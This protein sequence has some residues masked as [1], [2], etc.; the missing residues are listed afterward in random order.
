[1]PR[2]PYTLLSCAVSVDGCLDDASADRLILSGPED[3]DEVDELRAS[4]DAILVGAGTIRADDPRL[5]VRSPARAARRA[6]RGA[7]DQPLRVTLTGTGDLGPG[8]RFFLG[9][10]TPLVYCA[11]SAVAALAGRLGDAAVVV[12]AGDP[13]SLRNVLFDLS[14]RTVDSV[15]I[16]GGS[17]VLRDALEGDLA[18]ELRLAVAPF[19]VGSA[20]APR[21]GVPAGYPRTAAYP[22]TLASVRRVG[23]VS[24]SHYLLGAGAANPDARYLRH[25]IWLSRQ[26]VP[27]RS[28]F[29]V[30]AVIVSSSGEML[31][32]G[33][34]REQQDRDHA[35]EAALRKLGWPGAL[36]PRVRGATLYSSLVPCV[37]RASRPVPCA[38]HVI[39]AGIRRVVYAW[40]EP[41]V[42]TRRA[43]GAGVLR[44]GGIEVTELPDL[45]AEAAAVNAHLPISGR[46]SGGELSAHGRQNSTSS[47]TMPRIRA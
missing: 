36:D 29:S 45:A 3:L 19:F 9:P 8:A 15:L 37:A 12:G 32:C 25:A 14:E 7:P 17:R 39:A 27:A 4:V 28:A 13:P 2:R 10:G 33:Y 31:S 23:S 38:R 34:S 46:L 30:G 43:G 6:A 26:C 35:E 21:F 18:D 42:F 41:P 40:R 1:V 11:S 44:A 20:D 47:R 5:L 16:E 24:V 22:M